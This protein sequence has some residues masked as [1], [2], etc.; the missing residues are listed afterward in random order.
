MSRLD[1]KPASKVIWDLPT[2]LFHWLLV[3]LMVLLWYT[4]DLGGLDLNLP[5][6][7]GET[8]FVA[9]M[10][11]HMWLGQALLA[12]VIFRLFWGIFGSRTARFSSFVRGPKAVIA[13]FKALIRQG[14]PASF[15]HNPAG[16]WMVVLMLVLLAA[17]AVTGLFANDDIFSEGPLAHLVSSE[18]SGQLTEI[19]GIL[20]NGLLAAVA[21]HV[22]AILFYALRGKNLVRPMVTGRVPAGEGEQR[23]VASGWALLLL[24]VSGGLVWALRLL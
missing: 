11:L 17:Q 2:R 9:N 16:G 12:L 6:P 7:G 4:G 20:F 10:D 19:H 14:P 24:A 3:I 8:Y 13:Y 1:P 22:L 18:T 21:L 15:G 23:L 5:L